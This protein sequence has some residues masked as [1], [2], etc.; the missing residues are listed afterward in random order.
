M[1]WASCG[2]GQDQ[3][4]T[5]LLDLEKSVKT[6]KSDIARCAGNNGT[7]SKMQ[8]RHRS[9]Q[10]QVTGIAKLSSNRNMERVKRNM[11]PLNVQA[12]AHNVMLRGFSGSSA[13]DTRADTVQKVSGL[14]SSARPGVKPS[15]LDV[16]SMRTGALIGAA[17]SSGAAPPMYKV[18]FASATEKDLAKCKKAMAG[19]GIFVMHELI[20]QPPTKR[21][22]SLPAEDELYHGHK[23]VWKSDQ[24]HHWS[25][26]DGKLHKFTPAG[27]PAR[28]GTHLSGN[29]CTASADDGNRWRCWPLGGCQSHSL[30]LKCWNVNGNISSS[31]TWLEDAAHYLSEAAV[32]M[33]VETQS[34]GDFQLELLE[35]MF[36]QMVSMCIQIQL[37]QTATK[38][39]SAAGRPT[40][41][42][43]HDK[44][45]HRD[46]ASL[47]VQVSDAAKKSTTFG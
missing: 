24:L 41:C 44:L 14:F 46:D 36:I 15:I 45:F 26:D 29:A 40:T 4:E 5:H 37:M 32:I 7:M 47:W 43:L 23:P 38:R 1:R 16:V 34:C 10:Q 42:F 20:P 31:I 6:C 11:E 8:D 2:R 3:F 9:V 17:A 13:A 21:R 39:G 28:Q 25:K 27:P 22:C 33:A 18:M 12:R 30:T 35:L 19:K